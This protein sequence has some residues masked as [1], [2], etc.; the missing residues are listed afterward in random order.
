MLK[1]FFFFCS[2]ASFNGRVG[3]V[4]EGRCSQIWLQAYRKIKQLKRPSMFLATILELSIEIWSC[5][6]KVCFLR[7]SIARIQPQFKKKCQISTLG[8]NG[9]AKKEKD[10]FTILISYLA[11]QNWLNLHVDLH[12]FGYITKLTPK[13]QLNTTTHLKHSSTSLF[14]L[15]I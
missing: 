8:S 13:K 11:C 4:F 14:L 1:Q 12:H 7:F 10:V 9:L 2:K 3:S 6:I 5:K 15:A